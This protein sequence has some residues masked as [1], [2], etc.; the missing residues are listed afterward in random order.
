ML[1]YKKI[2]GKKCGFVVKKRLKQK[3]KTKV[4]NI[5]YCFLM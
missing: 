5:C 2:A 1:L 4:I 3:N